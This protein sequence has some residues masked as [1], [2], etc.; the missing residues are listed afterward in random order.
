[1]TFSR[2]S[3]RSRPP[4]RRLQLPRMRQ[5]SY[6]QDRSRKYSNPQTDG[7]QCCTRSL[8]CSAPPPRRGFSTVPGDDDDELRFVVTRAILCNLGD[9]YL[10]RPRTT[11]RGSMKSRARHPGGVLA[12]SRPK[13]GF[14]IVRPSIFNDWFDPSGFVVEY[15][16]DGNDFDSSEPTHRT[17]AALDNLHV[18]ASLRQCTNMRH[19]VHLALQVQISHPL[20]WSDKALFHVASIATRP[21]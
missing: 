20:F 12:I 9:V 15:Y 5:G 16:A 11:D 6:L 18:W 4:R 2:V 8:R 1:M 14:G 3:P 7:C 10:L 19:E 13:D 17:L 21:A